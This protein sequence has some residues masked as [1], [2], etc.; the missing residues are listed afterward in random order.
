MV[1]KGFTGVTN[2]KPR[3]YEKR[4]REIAR[5]AGCEGMVFLKNERHALPLKKDEMVALYGSGAVITRKGGTGSGDVNEREVVN[6]RDG[7]KGKG[8]PIA[9]EE[10][11]SD[12]E[13]SYKKAR[14]DWRDAIF[15]REKE[16]EKEWEARGDVS[17]YF[18]AKESAY[19]EIPFVAPAGSEIIEN[20]S[21]VSKAVYVISRVS[22]EG[23][24]RKNEKGD[25][26]LSDGERHMLQMICGCFSQVIC[27]LNTGGIMDLGFLEEFSNIDGVVFISQAGM[28]TGNAVADVL[29]GDVVPCGRL[30]D[31]WPYR[32]GD[33]PFA[34]EFVAVNG[35]IHKSYYKES[36]YVGYRYFDTFGVSVRYPFGYGLSYTKFTFSEYGVSVAKNGDGENGIEVS[37]HVKNVGER[38]AAKEVAQVYVSCPQTG[39]GKEFRRLC[40]YAKT[41]ELKPRESQELRIWIPFY[42]LCSF[43]QEKGAWILDE[44]AYY[45]WIGKNIGDLELAARLDLEQEACF[46]KVGRIAP[47]KE[48][49]EEL[50]PDAAR[51][52]A[53]LLWCEET[54]ERERITVLRVRAED[55]VPGT[56]GGVLREAGSGDDSSPSIGRAG[57]DLEAKAA[58]RKLRRDQK[59]R[60]VTGELSYSVGNI[61]NS[62]IEVPGASGQT[63][64]AAEEQG[65]PSIIFAD[66]PAGIR[67]NQSYEV[68]DGEIVPYEVWDGLENGLLSIKKEREGE[69]YYQYCTSIPIGTLLAQTWNEELLFELGRLVSEEMRMFGITLWLAPGMNIHRNPLCGRNFEYYS[70]DPFLSGKMAAAMTR[71]VQADGGTGVTVKHF[72]CNNQEE[73]RMGT[74]SVISERALREIYLKGFEIAVREAGPYGV[75][76]SYNLVNGIHVGNSMDLCTTVLRNE[77]GFDG[78]VM[79]DWYTTEP[80]PEGFAKSTKPYVC[81]KARN[82]LIMPGTAEDQ[83]NVEA[84]LEDGRLT[85][86]ELD[87]CVEDV[88]SVIF[89][90]A[91]AEKMDCKRE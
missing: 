85:E 2:K 67:V 20:G 7:L 63:S 37:L 3:E 6:I 86:E 55:V 78:L 10:W 61:G 33:Y 81:V 21:G 26:E 91:R 40:G 34:D 60:M 45:V 4:H 62:A 22:G 18:S 46:G 9:S 13:K 50:K 15:R 56:G 36:I 75:M 39:R 16:I 74:D 19:Y 73:N 70:E 89:R 57:F 27:L 1:R 48:S 25:Y 5:T 51:L 12:Y 17:E 52:S 59:V 30:A 38:Y 8:I 88:V 80:A 65:I 90:T 82:N 14:T 83:K 35:Q 29:V 49:L 41:K 77:W 58:V 32:Y 23:A 72:V 44:G 24:D 76:T 66:G 87:A 42:A 43:S 11:L 69:I 64:K 79:T 31:S 71:G 28:E 84:A 47:L 54:V 53:R 68:K